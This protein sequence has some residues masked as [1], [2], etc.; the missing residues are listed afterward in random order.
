MLTDQWSSAKTCK[1]EFSEENDLP[2]TAN[3]IHPSH[4]NNQNCQLL[5]DVWNKPATGVTNPTNSWKTTRLPTARAMSNFLALFGLSQ[6]V[7]LPVRSS[8]LLL[9]TDR[10]DIRL[11][12]VSESDQTIWSTPTSTIQT[13]EMDIFVEHLSVGGFLFNF[14]PPGIRQGHWKISRVSLEEEDTASIMMMSLTHPYI[15]EH[16]TWSYMID[17]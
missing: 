5:W 17:P 14:N 6:A 2:T 8:L 13:W 1:P 4:G 11:E 7:S 15:N 10:A 9:R 3:K 12:H 16:N